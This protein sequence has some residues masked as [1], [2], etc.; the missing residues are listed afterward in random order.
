MWAAQKQLYMPIDMV[1]VQNDMFLNKTIEDSLIQP[2][3]ESLHRY[4]TQL[5]VCKVAAWLHRSLNQNV[6]LPETEVSGTGNTTSTITD[7]TT[8]SVRHG[9]SVPSS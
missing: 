6:S 2:I 4:N 1:R 8:I 9:R 3:T 7:I 5:C